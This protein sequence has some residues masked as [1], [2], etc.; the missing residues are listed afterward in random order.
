MSD[1]VLCEEMAASILTEHNADCQK[2]GM[3]AGAMTARL[4]DVFKQLRL[5]GV[6]WQR[7]LQMVGPI[8]AILAGGGGWEQV[9]AA[10]LA[11]FFP[12]SPPPLPTA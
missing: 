5:R 3:M 1:D 6:N 11:L 4:G 10:V 7:I 2:R 9:L 12:P 8:L